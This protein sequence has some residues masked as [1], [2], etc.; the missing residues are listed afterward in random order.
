MGHGLPSV[1][2]EHTPNLLPKSL[3]GIHMHWLRPMGR[4]FWASVLFLIGL[5][6]VGYLCN[7]PKRAR[8]AT[9]AESIVG[10]LLVWVLLILGYGTIPHEWLQFAASYLNFGTDTFLLLT[11]IE[12]SSRFSWVWLW[13]SVALIVTPQSRDGTSPVEPSP[14]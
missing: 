14:L 8:K 7:K 6:I 10:A 12:T 4:L 3:F 13:F 2:A 1:L 9:W 11:R 5:A